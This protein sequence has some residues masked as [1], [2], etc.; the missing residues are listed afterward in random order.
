MGTGRDLDRGGT[1]PEVDNFALF[2]RLMDAPS[3]VGR[4]YGD[5][6]AVTQTARAGPALTRIVERGSKGGDWAGRLLNGSDYPLPAIMPLY[7]PRHLVEMR[8]L[9]P[10]AAEPL[11]A[12]RRHNALLFDFVLKRH[13]RVGSR[14]LADQL[15]E[16]RDFFV[17]TA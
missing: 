13:L 6:S 16:A 9:D 5:L 12:I 14:R 3:S 8:L 2:E 10:A 17:P 11:T 15:F 7:S 4:L 1:G